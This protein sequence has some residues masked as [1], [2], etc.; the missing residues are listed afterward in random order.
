MNPD[1]KFFCIFALRCK[2]K[3]NEE[4]SKCFDAW[5]KLHPDSVM[6]ITFQVYHDN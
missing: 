6:R 2:V 1:P 3:S 4:C 5:L